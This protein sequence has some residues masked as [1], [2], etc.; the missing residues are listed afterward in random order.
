MG[1][2]PAYPKIVLLFAFGPYTFISNMPVLSPML[3][4]RASPT[5]RL[6]EQKEMS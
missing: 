3:P 2:A 6:P 4:C 1:G 5:S